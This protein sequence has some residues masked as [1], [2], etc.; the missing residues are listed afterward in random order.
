M[1][2]Y[3]KPEME[4]IVFQHQSQLLAGSG[5]TMFKNQKAYSDP[6]LELEAD[7]L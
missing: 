5:P 2:K 4:V 7:Q 6:D 3:S 1:K